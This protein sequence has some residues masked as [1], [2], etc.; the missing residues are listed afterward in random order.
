[1]VIGITNLGI[2]I[3]KFM[4]FASSRNGAAPAAPDWIGVTEHKVVTF[5]FGSDG[6]TLLYGFHMPEVFSLHTTL[7][8]CV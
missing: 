1:M 2:D 6:G 5:V 7:S 4:R 3:P 8:F